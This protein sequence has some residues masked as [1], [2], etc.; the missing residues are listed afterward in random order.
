MLLLKV[1]NHGLT[2]QGN[3]KQSRLIEFMELSAVDFEHLV[4]GWQSLI[5]ARVQKV[6]LKDRVHVIHVYKSSQQFML[7]TDSAA[8]LT[9]AKLPWPKTPSGYCMFLRRRLASAKITAIRLAGWERIIII[10]FDTREGPASLVFELLGDVNSMFLKD[11]IIVSC[12][13][14]HNYGAR[15]IRGGVEYVQPA[16][17]PDPREVP[18][19]ELIGKPAAKTIAT[20]WSL[21]GKWA[22]ELCARTGID[23]AVILNEENVKV[24]YQELEAIRTGDTLAVHDSVDAFCVPWKTKPQVA[25][26]AASLDLAIE[27]VMKPEF[28]TKQLA[29]INQNVTTQHTKQERILEAQ[30]KQLE[31]LTADSAQSQRAGELLYE[32]YTELTALLENLK[33]DWKK[34]TLGELREK[35]KTNPLLKQLNEDGTLEVE[36]GD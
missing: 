16:A 9:T 23:R 17:R 36:L 10:D 26:S 5:G 25:T 12:H 7:F 15:V 30:R 33:D 13:S 24:L 27:A 28:E 8:F 20:A 34:M 35:Y 3:I 31:K 29:K 22:E 11:G 2:S 1:W 21:G 32:H 14:T 19:T 18:A 4:R 6:Y